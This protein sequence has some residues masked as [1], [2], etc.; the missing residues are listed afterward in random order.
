MA[1]VTGVILNYKK[2]TIFNFETTSP[3][4]DIKLTDT[5]HMV[6]MFVGLESIGVSIYSKLCNY[7]ITLEIKEFYKCDIYKDTERLLNKLFYNK[8]I[9]NIIIC[10]NLNDKYNIVNYKLDNILNNSTTLKKANRV[11]L[12][13]NEWK[14]SLVTNGSSLKDKEILEHINERVVGLD[15]YY[16]KPSK[17]YTGVLSCGVL[18]AYNNNNKPFKKG[19]YFR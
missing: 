10:R 11:L 16:K 7:M 8:C 18:L 1:K 12:Y 3:L 15:S 19:R 6:S 2:G 9:D 13:I 14:D 4:V 5:Q 17:E